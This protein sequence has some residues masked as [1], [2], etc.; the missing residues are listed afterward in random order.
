MK[1]LNAIPLAAMT[2]LAG[3]AQAQ[4]SVTMYGVVDVAVRHSTHQ[5]PTGDDSL[6]SVS[7]G[8]SAPSRLG[9]NISEDLGGGLKAIANM[10]HRFQADSGIIDAPG[11][12]FFQQS[13]VGLQNDTWG[14]VTLGRQYNVMFDVT[15]QTFVSFK[16]ISPLL[17]SFKPEGA[18]VLG[19]RNDNQVK[20]A[21]NLGPVTLEAQYS[22]GEGPFS[23]T[24][25]RSVGGMAKYASGPI[26]LG[27]GYIERKDDAGRK[28]QGYVAGAAYQQGPL[29][30]NA[31]YARNSFDD[32]LNT[33][34]L[35]IG[36]GIDNIVAG[37]SPGQIPTRVDN[38]SMWSLG[39]TYA[40]TTAL[41]LG[42]QYWHIDQEYHTPGALDAKGDF[43]ALLADYAFSKR[44]SVYAAL[45]YTHLDDLQLTNLKVTPAAPNGA[46][47][48]T[49]YMVGIRHRF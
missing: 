29:Y 27:A 33:A 23:S 5:G 3:T 11:T 19:A 14:R 32:G 44:T 35:L 17:N 6:T 4:T 18:M 43:A 42:A 13:W 16:P 15:A 31:F 48:R 34:L 24:T 9:W 28:A 8:G 39:G 22:A 47:N 12:V 26:A 40:L 25:G 46:T 41:T 20:Y 49:A 10:E 30:L 2:L 1:K 21:L 38:R 36:T 7:S 45:E 37:S